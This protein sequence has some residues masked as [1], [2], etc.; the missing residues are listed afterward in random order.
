MGHFSEERWIEKDV[1]TD[2]AHVVSQ[3]YA[4]E[5][6]LAVRIRIHESYTQPKS[7]FHAWVLDHIP[8]RGDEKVL[9]IGCGSGAYIEPVCQRLP[10]GGRLLAGDLSW[11]MLRSVAAKSLP[12]RVSLLNADAT[13]T[14]LPDGC[15][16]VVLANH[17]LGHITQIE[18][19][20]AEIRRVLRPGGCLVAATNARDSMH[21]FITEVAEACWALDHPTE[22][23]P[24]PIRLRFTLENGWAV[25]RPS[26]P[27]VRQETFKSELVF[28]EAAP[29]VAYINSLRHIYAPQLPEGL[30]WETLIKQVERQIRSQITAQGEYRV[31]KTTGVFIATLD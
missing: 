26:F 12:V 13:Q 31:A 15:C 14:P 17:V 23:T 18:A 10:Q 20:V 24:S 8:W 9:D 6:P 16:D 11:G 22:F 7:D 2:Q 30:A 28:F 3:M 29:P 21:V 19:A 5:E 1:T 4:T 27:T 25:L